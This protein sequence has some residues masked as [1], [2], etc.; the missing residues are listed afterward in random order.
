[1]KKIR[2]CKSHARDAPTMQKNTSIKNGKN[3][4]WRAATKIKLG[5]AVGDWLGK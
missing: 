5:S 2:A 3:T 4:L 1:M